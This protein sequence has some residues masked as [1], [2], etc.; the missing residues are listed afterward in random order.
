MSKKNVNMKFYSYSQNNSG[1][2]FVHDAEAGIGH[3]V[4]VEAKSALDADRRAESIGLYFDGSGDCECCGNRWSEQWSDEG[5][6]KPMIYDQDVSEGVYKESWMDWGLPSYIHYAD[7]TI[8]EV[9]HIVDKK[10]N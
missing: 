6:D 4:I 8:K 5:K 7:G 9:K 10:R 1:G 2:S 3:Y